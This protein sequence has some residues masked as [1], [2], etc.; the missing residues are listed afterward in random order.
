VAA[1]GQI[2]ARLSGKNYITGWD[3]QAGN[4]GRRTFYKPEEIVPFISPNI[5]NEFQGLAPFEVLKGTM[6]G[7][8]FMDRYNA[9][10]FKNYGAPAVTLETRTA[11]GTGRGGWLLR[12]FEKVRVALTGVSRRSSY[13]RAYP[14]T[15]SRKTPKTASFRKVPLTTFTGSA[16]CWASL[17][18]W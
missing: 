5:E 12:S 8:A 7:Q 2:K 16:G 15:S 3:Y 18:P 11:G 4:T 1:P 17:R 6:D 14:P 13:P 10:F 9:A